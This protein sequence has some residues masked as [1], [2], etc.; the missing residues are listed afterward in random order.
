MEDHHRTSLPYD[1][2]NLV[3]SEST[4][5]RSATN[6]PSDYDAEIRQLREGADAKSTAAIED[7][8]GGSHE[9]ESG[10]LDPLV[11]LPERTPPREFFK[12]LAK[13]R[14]RVLEINGSTFRV[15]LSS[16]SGGEP[17]KEAEIKIEEIDNEDR[18]LLQEGAAFYWSVGYEDRPSGRKRAS[19]LRFARVSPWSPR[20]LDRG[21]NLFRVFRDFFK[22]EK[23]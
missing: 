20:E 14:G 9:V 19:V 1:P 2:T 12:A 8:N 5:P 23:G 18:H 10:R 15:L 11:V 6:I 3:R 21:K 16:L 4:V 22:S 17:D 7:L 13:W